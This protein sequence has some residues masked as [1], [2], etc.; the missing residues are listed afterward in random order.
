MQIDMGDYFA[1]ALSRH[2]QEYCW[3]SPYRAPLFPVS[4]QFREK[5]RMVPR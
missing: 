3:G 1:C 5:P 4:G 2:G